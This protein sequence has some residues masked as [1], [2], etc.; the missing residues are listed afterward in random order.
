MRVGALAAEPR[1]HGLTVPA[2]PAVAGVIPG[3]GTGSPIGAGRTARSSSAGLVFSRISRVPRRISGL[4]DD[5]QDSG[6]RRRARVGARRKWAAPPPPGPSFRRRP[7]Q[8]RS[9]SRGSRCGVR[10][11]PGR[12]CLPACPQRAASGCPPR[13]RHRPQRPHRCPLG[14]RH[15]GRVART[16]GG[17]GR[18]FKVSSRFP[19]GAPGR[20][21]L[22]AS[23]DQQQPASST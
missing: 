15:I 6:A 3:A 23:E 1:R 21:V 17:A 8:A 16:R 18:R 9:R 12:C 19:Q 13:S 22:A 7:R 5:D 4:V 2:V 14:V 11:W 20:V 10:G